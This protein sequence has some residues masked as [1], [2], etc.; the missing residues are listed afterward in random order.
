LSLLLA[1]LLGS[2][3]LGSSGTKFSGHV[4]LRK[5]LQLASK[6]GHIEVT[7]NVSGSHIPRSSRDTSKCL[8][9]QDPDFVEVGFCSDAVNL[10]S[11]E[12]TW[13]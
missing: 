12:K 11:I 4:F 5:F 9:L 2:A 8:R 13:R 6:F 1:R 3:L 10:E 7:F